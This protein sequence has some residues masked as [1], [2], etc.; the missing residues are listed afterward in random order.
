MTVTV[1]NAKGFLGGKFADINV[2][3]PANTE[4]KKY[5]VL[6]AKSNGDIVPYEL[7]KAGVTAKGK[8]VFTANPTANDTITIANVTTVSK[9]NK[10]FGAVETDA[11]EFLAESII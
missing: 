6:G 10:A 3:V 11:Y 8:L 5:L 4:Y 2:K 7:A 9:L 1:D